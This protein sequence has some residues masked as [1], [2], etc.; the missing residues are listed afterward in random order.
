MAIH[1]HVGLHE[2]AALSVGDGRWAFRD[3]AE[4]PQVFED[5]GQLEAFLE[6]RGIVPRM[7][8]TARLRDAPPGPAG[9]AAGSGG[10]GGSGAGAHRVCGAVTGGDGPHGGCAHAASGQQPAGGDSARLGWQAAR[11]ALRTS[12]R[13]AAARARAPLAAPAP[14]TFSEPSLFT[15]CLTESAQPMRMTDAGT[16]VCKAAAAGYCSYFAAGTCAGAGGA[17]GGGCCG[18]GG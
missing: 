11:P 16:W 4:P 15:V 14:P 6:S 2:V 10:G 18:A 5:L 17:A 3:D 1:A 8:F 12:L 13:L 9:A 7:G